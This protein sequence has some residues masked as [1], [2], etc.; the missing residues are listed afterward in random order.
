MENVGRDGL[1]VWDWHVH[2]AVHWLLV[3]NQS[4][5]D[6]LQGLQYSMG[7]SSQYSVMA[8]MEKE[9]EK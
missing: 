3:T 2:V 7:K 4:P 5:I 9:S 6:W 8:Y 1:D